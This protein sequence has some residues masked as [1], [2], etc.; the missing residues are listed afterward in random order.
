MSYNEPPNYGTPPPPPAGGYGYGGPVGGGD[1]PQGTT[2]LILG[3]LSLICCGLFTGIPAI[4]MG[5]KALDES[6]TA[7]YNNAGVIKA[8]WICG[9]IGTALSALG[10]ILNIILI[11]AGASLY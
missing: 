6:K 2:I 8:G 5:K 9:I 1:H 11:A 7:N 10:I 4:I 3:I